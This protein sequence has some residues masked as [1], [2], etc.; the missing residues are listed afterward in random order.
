MI[1][2][3]HQPVTPIAADGDALRR[4][5][6]RAE[7]PHEARLFVTGPAGLT[8]LLWLYRHD[9]PGAVYVHSNRLVNWP[10]PADV[11]LIPH[12]CRP[13]ELAA[14]LG[15][16]RCVREGGALIVQAPPGTS[17][18]IVTVPSILA[19]TGFEVEALLAGHGY[20]VYV[21]RRVERFKRAA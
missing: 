17:H 3:S 4:A 18:D 16:G 7:A 21:A 13:D 20:S 12:A 1:T 14:I 9:Y 8:A 15:D 5:L 11:V 2:H 19:D 6:R 10:T